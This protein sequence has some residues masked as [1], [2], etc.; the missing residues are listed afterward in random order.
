[1]CDAIVT[2]L[3]TL[4][5]Q[6]ILQLRIYALY[7]QSRKILI[8]LIVMCSLEVSAMAILIGMTMS[9]LQGIPIISTETGCAYQ[10]LL[11]VSSVF[12]IPGLVY[13]PILFGLVAYK[14]WGKRDEPS[15]PLIVRMARDSLIY[16]AVIFVELLVSTVIWAHEPEWIN[17]F[18]PWSAALPSL[19]GSRLMLNMREAVYVQGGPDSY[20]METFTTPS[21]A[22]RPGGP[23][24]YLRRPSWGHP[25]VEGTLQFCTDSGLQHTTFSEDTTHVDSVHSAE[26]SGCSRA[27]SFEACIATNVRTQW[28]M[29]GFTTRT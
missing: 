8:F 19:L 23:S 9:H 6:I 11:S 14:A 25:R 1:M 27:K 7:E 4:A 24:R 5:V 20:I 18:N 3:A 16:F 21:P 17:L 15:V 29:A 13:E 28:V 26:F 10:A 12:W 2:T 22:G